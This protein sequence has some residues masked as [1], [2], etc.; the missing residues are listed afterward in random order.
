MDL[1]ISG[2]KGF[3]D[4][5]GGFSQLYLNFGS[6]GFVPTSNGKDIPQVGNGSLSTADFTKD[7]LPD[8]LITGY[9]GNNTRIS[10][11]FIFDAN[12]ALKTPPV[13][14]RACRALTGRRWRPATMTR[15]AGRT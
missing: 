1:V 5:D 9:A 8:L 12:R 7:G 10:K 6:D 11:F 3:S 14:C 2:W 4:A 13:E 15:M